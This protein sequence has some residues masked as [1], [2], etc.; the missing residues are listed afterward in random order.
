MQSEYALDARRLMDESEA[1]KYRKDLAERLYYKIRYADNLSSGENSVN[2]NRLK[3][4]VEAIIDFYN[5][6][7]EVSSSTASEVNASLKKI[8]CELED[9][10][11]YGRKKFS[12]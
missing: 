7:Y 6:M 2:Y 10:I 3:Q 8:K 9:N 12:L 11:S 4:Q 1:F 5:K